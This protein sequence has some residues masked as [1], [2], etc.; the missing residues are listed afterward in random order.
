MESR[1]RV[2]QLDLIVIRYRIGDWPW[3]RMLTGFGP[4]VYDV[5]Y[6]MKLREIFSWLA[7]HK[8]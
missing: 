6:S 3:S 1:R 2:F 7:V 8:K 5:L 4:V